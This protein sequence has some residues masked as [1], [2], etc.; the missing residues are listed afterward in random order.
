MPGFSSIDDLTS[1]LSAGKFWRQDWTKQSA[2][3]A[4]WGT[5]SF[6][7]CFAL[8]GSPAAMTW[9]GTTLV[10]QT[11]T[12]RNGTAT[13]GAGPGIWHGG[14]VSTDT[15]HVLNMGF[16]SSVATSVP[17]LAVLVDVVMYYPLVSNLTTT[18]Q[19]LINSNTF[20][21]SS[22]TGLLLTHANDFGSATHYTTV[23]FSNSGG[24]LPTGLNS[25][26]VFYL[27]RI[28]STTSKVAT[29][30]ANAVAASYVAYTDAGSGTNTITVTPSR[31]ADGVGLRAYVAEQS[32]SGSNSTGTPVMDQ[33]A[34]TGTEY[35]DASA[36]PGATKQF[37]AAVS[38]VTGA[39]NTPLATRIVHSGV[40]ANNYG[41]FLP[42]AVGG[43][44]IR[45]VDYYKLSTAYGAASTEQVA[46]VLCKPLATIPIVT[47]GAAGERNLLM[48]LPSLP[49][50][51]DGACLNILFFSGNASGLAASSPLMGYCEFGWG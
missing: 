26:D 48:Q 40:A 46:V 42:L 6:N 36:A 34:S 17:G 22:S 1:E 4:A 50:V 5:G 19:T 31:Y 11:P 29:T 28:S 33:T 30:H 44:G 25:T 15:K 32:R 2:A 35:T 43:S 39:A 37:G 47:A 41:P 24:A 51:Y 14:D 8:P 18:R 9:P 12:D 10:A 38:Y 23:K 3:T 27:C 13:L 49:R 20:T 21:A 16:Y 7:D 45:R